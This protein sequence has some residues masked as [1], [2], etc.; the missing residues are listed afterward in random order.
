MKKYAGIGSRTTPNPILINMELMAESL[1][2]T[3]ILRTGGAKG[4]DSAFVK[5]CENGN[6][7]N[8]EVYVPENGFNGYSS[9]NDKRVIDYIPPEAFKM[10]EKFH[11]SYKKLKDYVKKLMARNCMQIFGISMDDPVDFIIC[12]THDGKAS[13]G[14]GQAMRIATDKNIKIYNLKKIEDYMEAKEKF[15]M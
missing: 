6:P 11:P 14:T 1:S 12:Y 7:Q 15:I 13:G 8:V 2:R 3:H 9:T 10:A 4:A 5:G